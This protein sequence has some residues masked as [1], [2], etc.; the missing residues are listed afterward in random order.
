MFLL[1]SHVFNLIQL[2]VGTIQAPNFYKPFSLKTVVFGLINIL[3][4]N[5]YIF[6]FQTAKFTRLILKI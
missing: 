5:Y 6:V 3:I 2:R 4:R 1:E